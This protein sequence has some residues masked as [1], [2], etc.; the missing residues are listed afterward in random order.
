[1]VTRTVL[2]TGATRGIGRVAAL[3]LAAKGFRVFAAGRTAEALAS[4]AAES[5][6]LVEAVRMDVTDE[7]SI[8]AAREQVD[9]ATDGGG[10]DALV[11]NAG[12]G[13]G[14][15]LELLSDAEVRAQFE[16]N[17]FGLLAATRAF[18]PRMR[19]RRSGR[20]VHVGSV[21][22]HVALPF[23]GAYAATKH[24]LEAISDAMR[25]ELEPFGVHVVLI[26]PGAI[27]T[28]FGETEKEGLRKYAGADSPYA[29]PLEAFMRWH[30]G[31][32]PTAP[33]P[34]CVAEAIER[35]LTDTPPRD[36]YHAPG[37]TAW[38]MRIRTMLPTSVSDGLL[39]RLSG[40]GRVQV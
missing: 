29:R 34:E 7:A 8:A 20:I 19:E 11:N 35:A 24:A 38:L 15:P 6:G 4:L 21:S 31:F 9:R 10:V 33:G 23:L 17:V 5:G 40:L 37:R 18:L 13:Q 39:K 28:E 2:I 22:G 14:G 16:T 30:A 36:R 26:K 32:H 25:L 27:N 1:M 12:Y 3:H